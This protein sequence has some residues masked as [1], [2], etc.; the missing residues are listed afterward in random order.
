MLNY[1]EYGKV[2]VVTGGDRGIG[3]GIVLRLAE[4]GYDIFTT[5]RSREDYA[6]TLKPEVEAIGR[7][8][9]LYKVDFR[10]VEDTTSVIPEAIKRYGRVDLVVNNAAILPPRRYQYEYEA[11]ELDAVYSVNYRGY[12][13]LM[14]DAV[15]HWIKNGL[16]GNIVNISSESAVAPHQKFSLYGGIKAAICQSTRSVALDV[17][18]YGIR[19]NAVVPGLIAS[20]TIEEYRAD[21]V[22]EK[23]IAATEKFKTDV[24]PLRRA[25]DVKEIGNAICWL[26]SDEALYITGQCLV[27]DGGL[28]LT[29]QTNVCADE[30]EEQYGCLTFRNL[31][32]DDMKNW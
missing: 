25:G 13:L 3:R 1:N 4:A 11:E 8:C 26:A 9:E 19:V 15:R 22:P 10:S 23:E 32:D 27:V 7:R 18:P 17:A 16:K 31:R 21:G 29:G 30:T 24:I 14:R 28:T 6:V 12:M 2:A 5:Y 20:K